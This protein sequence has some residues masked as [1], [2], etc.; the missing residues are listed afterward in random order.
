MKEHLSNTQLDLLEAV[1]AGDAARVEVLI[2]DGQDINKRDSRGR[3]NLHAAISHGN[4]SLAEL[5]LRQPGV[6]TNTT[7]KNGSSPLSIAI[8]KGYEV[9]VSSILEHCQT[10]LHLRNPQ[11]PTL[12]GLA[13]VREEEPLTY[14]LLKMGTMEDWDHLT[15]LER[16]AAA[17]NAGQANLVQMLLSAYTDPSLREQHAEDFGIRDSIHSPTH[18]VRLLLRSEIG[19]GNVGLRTTTILHR[20]ARDGYMEIVILLLENGVDINILDQYR[21]TPLIVACVAGRKEIAELLIHKETDLQILDYDWENA[22]HKA[23]YSGNTMI[24]EMLLDQGLSINTVSNRGSP[25]RI[26]AACGHEAM[27]RLLLDRGAAGYNDLSRWEETLL[28]FAA[29]GGHKAVARILLAKGADVNALDNHRRTP[30]HRASMRGYRRL[31]ELM[32]DHGADI[33]A[34]TRSGAS[35]L[36]MAILQCREG[37][38]RH[39]VE[40]G[41]KIDYLAVNEIRGLILVKPAAPYGYCRAARFLIENGPELDFVD[42]LGIALYAAVIYRHKTVVDTLLAAGADVNIKRTYRAVDGTIYSPET[43]L[44]ITLAENKQSI[45]QKLIER[46]AVIDAQPQEVGE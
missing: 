3:T 46:G 32:L 27:L 34:I 24:A 9:I 45:V 15:P 7:D 38:V 26:A 22:L 20:A 36:S 31:V 30:L 40:K 33:D 2:R 6:M 21:Q 35:A 4:V 19:V 16:L 25:L 1:R 5:L 39:L 28:H 14:H 29:N 12:L 37:I 11:S 41:A 23:A 43:P 18:V 8:T 17:A 10:D 44:E 13:V 42:E